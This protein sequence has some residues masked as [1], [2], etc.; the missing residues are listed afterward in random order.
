ME[1]EYDYEPLPQWH[2]GELGLKC[3]TEVVLAS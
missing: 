2:Q 1:A 3:N